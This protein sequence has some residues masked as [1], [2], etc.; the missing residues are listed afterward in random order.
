M[1]CAVYIIAQDQKNLFD[2]QDYLIKDYGIFATVYPRYWA[3]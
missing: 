1:E 2:P 3:E